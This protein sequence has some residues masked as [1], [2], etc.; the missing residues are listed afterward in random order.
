MDVNAFMFAGMPWAA[1]CAALLHAA[2]QTPNCSLFAV[3]PY[4]VMGRKAEPVS[5]LN[6]PL[7]Q[8]EI[9]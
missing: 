3:R 9:H 2:S 1:P 7:C 8:L 5:L 6:P 4:E